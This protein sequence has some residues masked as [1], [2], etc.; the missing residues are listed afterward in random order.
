MSQAVLLVSTSDFSTIAGMDWG[1][2]I[3]L[4][5]AGFG[6][7]AFKKDWIGVTTFGPYDRG[8]RE[9]FGRPGRLIGQ[10]PHPHIVGL[11]NLRRASVAT[12]IISLTNRVIVNEHVYLY[13]FEVSIHIKDEIDHIR[14]AIYRTF[15]ENKK[16]LYNSQRVAYVKNTLEQAI[17]EL[18]ETTGTET[19]VSVESLNGRCKDHLLLMCGTEIDKVMLTEFTPVDAQIIKDG[20]LESGPNPA[21][22]TVVPFPHQSTG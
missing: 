12:S 22:R 5:F 6:V 4:V 17:R 21:A 3:W 10:G 14:S 2:L 18:I 11:G 15:D 16:D 19:S 20:M 9:F 13:I 7:W 8:F 1:K